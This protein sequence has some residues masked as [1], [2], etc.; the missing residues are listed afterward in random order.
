MALPNVGGNPAAPAGSEDVVVTELTLPTAADGV[1]ERPS[2]AD[3]KGV[4]GARPALVRAGEAT[5][6]CDD[7]SGR[8]L[9][10]PGRA[11]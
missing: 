5:G 3:R 10:G 11:G 4:G 1:R 6:R 7:D 2:G 8:G 9:P